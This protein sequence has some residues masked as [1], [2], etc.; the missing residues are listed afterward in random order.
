[1]LLV[2]YL[3]RGGLGSRKQ[4]LPLLEA[5]RVCVDD[6]VVRDPN[7]VVSGQS[8][9]MDSNKVVLGPCSLFAYHKPI[10]CLCVF[11]PHFLA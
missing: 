8:V 5:G 10:R 4:V 11:A 6:V 3:S 2:R 9:S 7:F 1:M